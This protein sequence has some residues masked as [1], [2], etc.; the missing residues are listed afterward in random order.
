MIYSL[1]T[2]TV[3]FDTSSAGVLTCNGNFDTEIM[4]GVDYRTI[5]W[6]EIC[7]MAARPASAEKKHAPAII[8]S[9]YHSHDGREHAAQRQRGR[10]IMLTVDVDKGNPAKA[11]VIAAVHAV[12]G[13]QPLDLIVYSTSSATQE[14]RKWRALVRLA[15][16]LQ[17]CDF[18]E[19][20]EALFDLLQAEGI[21]CDRRLSRTGQLVYLPNVPPNRRKA[22]GKAEAYG[23]EIEHQDPKGN[24]PGLDLTTTPIPAQV[25]KRRLAREAAQAK[26]KADAAVRA[27]RRSSEE[28]GSTI[29]RYNLAHPVEDLLIKYG[30]ETDGRGNWQSPNQESG[31]FAT[32]PYEDGHWVSLSGSDADA[33]LGFKTT[34]G[35]RAGDSFDLFV[36]YEHGGDFGAALAAAHEKLSADDF[37]AIGPDTD[38]L[39]KE[40]EARRERQRAENASIGREMPVA[41]MPEILT[42]EMALARFAFATDGSRVVDLTCPARDYALSD[43]H[44]AFGASTMKLGG[45]STPV[46]VAWLKSP[47]RHTVHS[48]TF[49]PGRGQFTEDPRNFAAVNTWQPFERLEPSG[50]YAEHAAVFADHVAFLFGPDAP[51][52]L[53]WL[54]HLEQKPGE[55]PHTGW[56]HIS[57]RTGTGRNAMA[58]ILARVWRGRVAAAFNLS[59]ALRDG[60]NDDLAGRLLAIVD[61]IREGTN[62]GEW[63]HAETVKAMLTAERRTIN[64]KFGRKAVEFNACRWL[65]FSNHVSAIPLQAEDRRFEVVAYEGEPKPEAYYTRLYGLVND[66][67]FIADVT[68]FLSR[69]NISSFNPGRHAKATA[70]KKA[71]IDVATSEAKAYAQAVVA[72][73]PAD[74]IPSRVLADI[75]D[76]AAWGEAKAG[77]RRVA[78]EVGM[79]RYEKTVK[80]S[81]TATRVYI[82]RNTERWLSTSSGELGT[83]AARGLPSGVLDTFTDWR[84][85]LDE[86]TAKEAA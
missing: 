31:S 14:D 73:W 20:E 47:N 7:E 34:S 39:K 76:P 86:I 2:D 74:V 72:H 27:A 22:D 15:Q 68:A 62:E 28:G 60:F 54:A 6:A 35:A 56:L 81:G 61:E 48:R 4:T 19:T 12:T 52:F 55:L 32:K 8:P 63:A 84:S 78:S 23:C 13:H 10:F 42:L 30:Y 75:L 59:Q 82:I 25:E 57:S 17:G 71:V 51:R 37:K 46:S 79:R 5:T 80:I 49:A 67:T 69:R 58:G 38:Y 64:P 53:D 65:L 26:A 24:G 40:R 50:N 1:Y 70:A 77:V 18:S 83:E 85:I 45:R 21:I 66:P 29:E 41:T 3:K 16:P 43:F 36:H 9:I 33:G 11:E 44:N